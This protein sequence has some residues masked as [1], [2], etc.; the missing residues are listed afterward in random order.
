MKYVYNIIFIWFGL[1]LYVSNKGI[2]EKDESSVLLLNF[3]VDVDFMN[4]L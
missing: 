4:G 3:N 1:M 2:K